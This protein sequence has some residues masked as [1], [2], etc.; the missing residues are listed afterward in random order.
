MKTS[1]GTSTRWVAPHNPAGSCRPGR[2]TC[3]GRGLA[4]IVCCRPFCALCASQ[5]PTLALCCVMPRPEASACLWCLQFL[6]DKWG[7]AVGRYGPDFVYKDIEM[8][9]P[10]SGGMRWGQLLSWLI[11]PDAAWVG[12]LLASRCRLINRPLPPLPLSSGCL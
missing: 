6:V 5:G 8:V 9:G 4:Q 10:G 1:T 7:H 2:V 3:A 12:A 11:G